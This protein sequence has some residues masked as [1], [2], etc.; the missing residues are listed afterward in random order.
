M[1]SRSA[2]EAFVVDKPVK[3]AK[4]AARKR[5]AAARSTTPR[6]RK[7]V[8]K[9]Q[10]EILEPD[11]TAKAPRHNLR[12][13]AGFGFVLAVAV[14]ALLVVDRGGN[15]PAAAADAPVAVSAGKLA[16]LAGTQA[17]YWAGPQRSRTLELT[18]TDAATFVRYLP[19]GAAVG[20]SSRSLT[21]ATYPLP[22][23]YATAVRRAKG[24]AM[25][26]ARTENGGLA[27]WSKAQPT[28]VY[29]A[30]RGVPSLVEVYAPQAGTARSFALSAQLRPVR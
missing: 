25:A 4:P 28:S 15:G 26:S 1:S 7:T 8:P 16:T 11:V 23:A 20:G 13:I 27:V 21:I 10:V 24:D 12:A 14:G 2:V 30:F 17:V 29:V 5:P 9:P 6:P 3:A 19:P 18:R 22:N